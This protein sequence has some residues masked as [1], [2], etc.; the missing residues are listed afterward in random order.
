MAD[1]G[2]G[3]PAPEVGRGGRAP[4][5]GGEG[6]ASG[7]EAGGDA[8]PGPGGDAGPASGATVEDQVGTGAE[9]R[10]ASG[11]G[12]Q[13]D[14]PAA[15]DDPVG[16]EGGP[17]SGD[18]PATAGPD[19]ET[20]DRRA[21]SAV[22]PTGDGSAPGGGDQAGEGDA[23]ATHAAGGDE[24][25]AVDP[26]TSALRSRDEVLVPLERDLARRLKRILADEQN[27]VLDRL[28]RGGDVQLSDVLPDADEHAARYAGAAGPVL[29][30]AAS[31]G[32]STVGGEREVP[33]DVLAEELGR[34]LT[35]PLRGRV[36]RSLD[37]SDGDLDEVTERL[38]ALYREWK[39]Q[40]IA[41]AVRHY[42]VAAYSAGVAGAL[43]PGTAQR[44]LVDPSC[45]SCPDCDD[46][47]L[48]GEVP[49]GQ[50]FP[51]GDVA[52]PAHPDCRCLVVPA[53]ALAVA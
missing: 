26:V 16:E 8:P 5:A 36:Q 45:A 12:V 29:G 52:P 50:A 10:P 22:P 44:W 49:G 38:R 39:G 1:P 37:E 47:A 30:V 9:E 18:R 23:R 6:A 11:R 2:E 33:C 3:G 51:T 42:S 53:T 19:P 17:G 35:G 34:S 7:G 32:R 28:R 20:G 43:A 31:H 24:A 48:A 25:G 21:R 4:A 14:G 46:N 13:G 41:G 27:E 15:G 40:R